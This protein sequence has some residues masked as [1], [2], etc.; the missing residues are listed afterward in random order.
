MV[1]D[2]K[3]NQ[4]LYAV[5]DLITPIANIN[6]FIKLGDSGAN[7]SD[8]ELAGIIKADNYG[9]TKQ[10]IKE[11]AARC[12]ERLESFRQRVI[13]TEAEFEEAQGRANANRPGSA[14]GT[15]FLDRTDHNAVARHNERVNEYNNQVDLHRR[16]VDQ[17][18]RS[19]ERYEDALER[20][21]EKK[22]EVEEQV[23]EKME[24]LKPALDLDMAAFLGKLQQLV[25][26]CFHNKALIF[27]SFILLF[28]AKKAYVFLYDRIESNSER[29]TASNT[30]RQLN[31]EL[32]TLVENHSDDLKRGF[33]EIV[34]YLYEC[35]CENEAI[36]DTMQK[37]LE[38]LPYDICNSNDDSAHSLTSLVIDTNFQYKEIIDPNELARVA[39]RIQERRGQ[40]E[41][42]IV[43]IDTFT[44]QMSETFDGIAE[45]LA[46]SKTKL[47][48]IRQ[49]KET[50][51]GEAF[52]YSRFTLGVFDEEIQDEYLKQQKALL[53]AM[54]LE[55]ETSLGINL[56]DLIET[57]LETELL[58]VSAVQA[59]DTNA[60]FGFLKYRQ[61]LQKKRQEFT[62]G[63]NTLDRQLEEISRLPEEKSQEFTKQMLTLLGISILPL[64]NLGALFPVHQAI[65]KFVPALGSTHPVYLEL[66][67]KT[68]GKLQGFAI[69]HALIAVLIGASTFAVK[70]DQKPFA[71]GGAAAYGV[72]AGVLFMKKKQLTNL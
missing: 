56:I 25:Y 50:R 69:A 42:K 1:Y 9:K 54:Q 37:L 16:L 15:L 49:N 35:F 33:T 6:F 58:C 22:A 7:Y 57:I 11:F 71:I 28:M 31:G 41:N 45:V 52:D 67:E 59:I 17:A 40:F 53:E 32:E 13:E 65:T 63:I 19:K 3:G 2:V 43:E 66:R 20:F 10:K 14:P 55:I 12:E 47:Q 46:D 70:D 21:K 29:N 62:T 44:N 68:K 36:F 51:M 23:R 60:A 38:Q 18:L 39:T 5:R 24:E 30:F 48:L 72:S 61:K 27:E 4:S 8:E 64:G 26:D 34:T